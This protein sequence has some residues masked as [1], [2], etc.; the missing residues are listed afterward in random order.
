MTN[1]QAE[2]L[3]EVLTAIANELYE[4]KRKTSTTKPY[5]KAAIDD[6]KIYQFTKKKNNQ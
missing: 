5:E 3:I 1:Q 2:E 4:I 6:T